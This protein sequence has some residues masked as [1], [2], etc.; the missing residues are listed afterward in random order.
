MRQALSLLRRGVRFISRLPGN[1]TNGLRFR[2]LFIRERWFRTPTRIRV[3]GRDVRLRFLEEEGVRDDFVDCFIRNTYGLGHGLPAVSTILDIGA[4][5][6]FFSL[7]AREY[8][9]HATI[10]AYEPNPRIV[11]LL[12]S[13][14]DGL[15]VQ[16]YPEAVGGR[17]GSIVMI[18][19]GA[20]NAAQTRW[21]ESADSGIRQISLHTAIERM[22]GSVDLLKL[23]CEG[24]EWEMFQLDYCWKQVRH[25][26]MEVHLFRGETVE[27]AKE[28]LERL[29][30][31]IIH[32]GAQYELNGTIWASRA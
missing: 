4:N 25:I 2:V 3:A 1:F 8:Y 9:P 20:S 32:W 12:S 22:G 18:D 28:A 10:H 17:S 7:A 29:G 31:R 27:Q 14:I 23:D 19:E 5:V 11:T 21:S 30:F 15:R 6:G 16:G 24:A 13:N 26:R